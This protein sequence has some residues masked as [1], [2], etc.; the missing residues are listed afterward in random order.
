MNT[1]FLQ[2]SVLA[3]ALLGIGIGSFS[4]PGYTMGLGAAQVRSGIGQPLQVKVPVRADAS[5]IADG[6][7]CF[8]LVQSPH[9]NGADLPTLGR[10]D[11]KLIQSPQ[12]SYLMLTTA[13][14]INDPVLDFSVESVCDNAFR[15]D[16]TVLIDTVQSLA[17]VADAAPE[18]IAIP[19]RPKS[20]VRSDTAVSPSKHMRKRAAPL[21]RVSRHIL[22]IDAG[23]Q[24]KN[25]APPLSLRAAPV[26]AASIPQTKD[27]HVSLRISTS[28]G[29]WPQQPG[30][31]TSAG[32]LNNE[33]KL[34]QEDALQ[35]DI[36]ALQKQLAETRAAVVVL[37]KQISAMSAMTAA[38]D[39]ARKPVRDSASWLGWFLYLAGALT[40]G[41]AVLYLLRKYRRS[42]QPEGTEDLLEQAGNIDSSDPW[43]ESSWMKPE[44]QQ[45]VSP[46]DQ[47]IQPV[48]IVPQR[49]PASRIESHP[50]RKEDDFLVST[51]NQITE[52]ATVFA[53]LGYPERAM[54]L[55]TEHIASHE[56]SHPAV[57]YL[58]FELYRDNGQQAEFEEAQIKFKRR[59]NL[60]AP[61]W[62]DSVE[63]GVDVVGIL[64]FPHVLECTASLWPTSDCR[65]YLEGLLYDDRGGEREGFSHHTYQ[66]LL[67]LIGL[68]EHELELVQAPEAGESKQK[69]ASTESRL[70]LI[71]GGSL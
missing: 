61:L 65:T 37:R 60:A 17:K 71:Q 34:I 10:A 54:T 55:L 2:R 3:A 36:V 33:T 42:S 66:D 70:R 32:Q 69:L 27:D 58:L 62:K 68:L 53:D 31:I 20:S 67:F 8:R 1:F 22:E 43:T 29:T 49:V 7:A 52:E 6:T 51:V 11:L 39:A 41:T 26:S 30:S 14:P 38:T 25:A 40:T 28:L 64:S 45:P 13:Y 23:T 5:E 19:T 56:R 59:F 16:Y 44:T 4:L 15:R 21:H 63:N 12:G 57:W 35:D 50:G 9:H 46:P 48:A 24:T 47:K 18:A